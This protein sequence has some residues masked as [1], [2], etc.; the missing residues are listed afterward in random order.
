VLEWRPITY[1]GK[2]SYGIYLMHP[3]VPIG[4]AWMAHRL[5]TEY[6]VPRFVNFVLV[7][8]VT[9]GLAALSWHLFER[10][11]NGLKRFFPYRDTSPSRAARQSAPRVA[12]AAGQVRS[13][14]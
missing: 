2:V 1:L 6:D 4:F 11:I 13:G 10:P 9:A 12:A 7:T 14:E 8:A 5:G 3:F